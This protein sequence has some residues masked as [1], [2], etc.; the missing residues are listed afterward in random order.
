[1][2]LSVHTQL[3]GFKYVPGVKPK[4]FSMG[5]LME[6]FAP[7][8]SSS[9]EEFMAGVIKDKPANIDSFYDATVKILFDAVTK[10]R[11]Y[12]IDCAVLAGSEPTSDESVKIKVTFL[13]SGTAGSSQTDF[14]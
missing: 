12:C 1:M 2:D 6:K 7:E 8:R 14:Y 4:K 11:E 3:L 9:F 5:Y 13:N 10:L